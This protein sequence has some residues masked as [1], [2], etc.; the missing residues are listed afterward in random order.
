VQRFDKGFCLRS[1]SG[2]RRSCNSRCSSGIAGS[3]APRSLADVASDLV[4]PPSVT[5]SPSSIGCTTD[6]APE[7]AKADQVLINIVDTL[8]RRMVYP[9]QFSY[10]DMPYSNSLL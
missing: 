4:L 10:G 5:R 3:T 8:N 2:E 1:C 7:T 6:C 9:P